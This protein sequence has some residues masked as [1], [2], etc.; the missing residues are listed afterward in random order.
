VGLGTESE[1]KRV[2]ADKPVPPVRGG[3]ELGQLGQK[4][5]EGR[6]V[7][8]SFAFLFILNFQTLF[9]LFSLLNSNPTKPEIQI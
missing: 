4:G 6:E 5:W 1:G 9:L 2:G 8:A 3:A 7:W